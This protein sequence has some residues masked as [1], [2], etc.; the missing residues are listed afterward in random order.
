M[1]KRAI[2]LWNGLPRNDDDADGN[3]IL[4]DPDRQL[5]ETA[6]QAL[7]KNRDERPVTIKE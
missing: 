5:M 1:A 4:I 7:L 6:I 2:T 3:A